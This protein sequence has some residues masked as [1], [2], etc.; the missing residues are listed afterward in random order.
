VCIKGHI[1][2]G[3][4]VLEAPGRVSTCTIDANVLFVVAC[5]RRLVVRVLFLFLPFYFSSLLCR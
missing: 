5:V 3:G 1:H 2:F 4:S